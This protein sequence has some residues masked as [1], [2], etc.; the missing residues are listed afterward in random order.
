ME[1]VQIAH[2][3]LVKWQL[4]K[5]HL[6]TGTLASGSCKE[7]YP[8]CVKSGPSFCQGEAISE[9]QKRSKDPMLWQDREYKCAWSWEE[10]AYTLTTS[11]MQEMRHP[12]TKASKVGIII[13]LLKKSCHTPSHNMTWKHCCTI[14]EIRIIIHINF[15]PFI[16]AKQLKLSDKS[17]NNKL[18][19][20]C[21]LSSV[22][23][24]P[25]WNPFFI[26]PSPI[27]L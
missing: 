22:T 3:L 16:D 17:I 5:L 11:L 21:P 9:V 10:A 13:V 15:R 26:W 24:Q 27:C 6:L 1:Q 25:S 7:G 23:I 2:L 8:L 12:S 20:L 14:I 4:L 19:S 18:C